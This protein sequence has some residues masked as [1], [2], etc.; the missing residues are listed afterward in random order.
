MEQYQLTNISC[1][2]FLG[3][4]GDGHTRW[5]VARRMR[6]RERLAN[7]PRLGVAQVCWQ[8]APGDDPGAISI[9]S[10]RLV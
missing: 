1:C 5:G 4:F 8:E 7:T 3:I 2:D 6:M 10:I 9:V